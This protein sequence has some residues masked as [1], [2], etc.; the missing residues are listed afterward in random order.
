MSGGL[1]ICLEALEAALLRND[2]AQGISTRNIIHGSEG[3][4]RGCNLA[5]GMFPHLAQMAYDR[6]CFTL[7]GRESHQQIEFNFASFE[8]LSLASNSG[9]A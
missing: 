4:A 3:E 2:K 9:G 8:L 6:D 7:E 1:D 5:P